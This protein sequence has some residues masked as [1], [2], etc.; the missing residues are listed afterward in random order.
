MKKH[1]ISSISKQVLIRYCMQN[2]LSF[3][4]NEINI[5]LFKGNVTHTVLHQ[6]EIY[7]SIQD[8]IFGV[9]ILD[10]N[11]VS[12]GIRW[13]DPCRYKKD[14][15]IIKYCIVKIYNFDTYV[16]AMILT[17]INWRSCVFLWR[18]KVYFRLSLITFSSLRISFTFTNPV[19]GT[20]FNVCTETFTF[21]NYPVITDL[22][23]NLVLECLE[24]FFFLNNSEPREI[25][26]VSLQPEPPENSLVV[27][28]SPHLCDTS[29]DSNAYVH[30]YK[31]IYCQLISGD[32]K[33]KLLKCLSEK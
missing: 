16:I 2:V 24:R 1:P 10:K 22:L 9:A 20:R 21:T 11:N 4:Q 28:W 19:K 7:S 27:S 13:Q 12:S 18:C 26:D 17:Q 32:C 5:L 3:F 14:Y 8:V 29:T 31:I 30:F 15:G 23:W 6:N 25:R 33:G